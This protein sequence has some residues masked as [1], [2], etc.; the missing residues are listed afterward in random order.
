MRGSIRFSAALTMGRAFGYSPRT[1]TSNPASFLNTS[2]AF[3]NVT[4]SPFAPSFTGLSSAARMRV[5]D[6]SLHRGPLPCRF[7]RAA[8][9]K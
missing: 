3:S 6:R 5:G 8:T 2:S 4:F 7:R 1:G 9:A